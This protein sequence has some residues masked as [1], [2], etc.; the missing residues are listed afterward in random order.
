MPPCTHV[1]TELCARP[2]RLPAE[3]GVARASPG[4]RMGRGAGG[5]SGAG[6]QLG[7]PGT[8]ARSAR[9]PAAG[10]TAPGPPRA[11]SAQPPAGPASSPPPL[12]LPAARCRE[13][14]RP[15]NPLREP[16]GRGVPVGD[17]AGQP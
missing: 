16:W 17:R 3:A 9:P 13:G 7:P 14:F 15:Q 2:G 1:R 11:S 5:V 10:R 8:D 6:A 12:P 4:V